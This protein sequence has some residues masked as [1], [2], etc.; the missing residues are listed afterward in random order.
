MDEKLSI[1]TNA[2]L[3]PLIDRAQSGDEVE[4]TR[5]G[6]VV[7]RLVAAA[8]P[9]TPEQAAEAAAAF[10]RIK[11]RRKGVTLGGLKIKDLINEG[12]RF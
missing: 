3:D 10:E 4:I 1:E 11:E 8:P 5:D 7:A 2:V 9:P 12:R 6:E